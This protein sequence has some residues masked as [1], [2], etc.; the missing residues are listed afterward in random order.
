VDKH[1]ISPARDPFHAAPRHDQDSEAAPHACNDGWVSIGQT[2]VGPRDG[3]GDRGVRAV[4]VPEVRGRQSQVGRLSGRGI[5]R[6]VPAHNLRRGIKLKL[7]KDV[8]VG[9]ELASP[10]GEP[11]PN[12]VVRVQQ[13]PDGDLMVTWSAGNKVTGFDLFRPDEPVIEYADEVGMR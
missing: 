12:R 8:E 9:D 3:R 13:L 1:T 7:A 4:F 6:G 5:L 2:V 10:R 11:G